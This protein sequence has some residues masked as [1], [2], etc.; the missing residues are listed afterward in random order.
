MSHTFK[1]CQDRTRLSI[2]G[3]QVFHIDRY[4]DKYWYLNGKRHR[5]NGPAIE[6]EFADGYKSWWYLN[7]RCY[8]ESD[9][10]KEIRK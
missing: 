2:Y 9:Y 5:E 1:W 10:W 4:G 6:I 7:G 3:R 8:T